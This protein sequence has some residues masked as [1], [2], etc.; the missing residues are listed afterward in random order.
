MTP[1]R[2]KKNESDESEPV[3]EEES[4]IKQRVSFP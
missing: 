2:Q 4:P 3:E 1:L